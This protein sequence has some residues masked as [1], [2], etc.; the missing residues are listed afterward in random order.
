M[1]HYSVCV[2]WWALCGQ[3]FVG[4]RATQLMG[5]LA[6]PQNPSGL[7]T[8]PVQPPSSFFPPPIFPSFFLSSPS[9]LFSFPF[10]PVHAVSPVWCAVALLRLLEH[11][12]HPQR[13]RARERDHHS[14]QLSHWLTWHPCWL[15]HQG[16]HCRE[17]DTE[18][19]GSVS[20]REEWG[21]GMEGH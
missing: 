16:K 9:T 10:P 3:C 15:R 17:G 1:C 2:V 8:A 21:A 12:S 4:L 6:Q 14:W 19:C 20:F 13:E 7:I 11:T 5:H 18:G